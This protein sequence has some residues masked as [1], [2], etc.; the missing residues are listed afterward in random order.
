MNDVYELE[1]RRVARVSDEQMEP[2]ETWKGIGFVVVTA[3]FL[4]GTFASTDA[5]AEFHQGRL[6][7]GASRLGGASLDLH[8]WL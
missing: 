7:V 2:L 5:C 3:L 1:D 8:V 6:E 4:V